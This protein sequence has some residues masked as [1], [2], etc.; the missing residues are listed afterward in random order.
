[1][2]LRVVKP[3]MKKNPSWWDD[4]DDDKGASLWETSSVNREIV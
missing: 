4:V 3:K 1:M 2:R